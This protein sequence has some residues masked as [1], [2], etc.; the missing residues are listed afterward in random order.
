MVTMHVFE[1]CVNFLLL[2]SRSSRVG[3]VTGYKLDGGGIRFLVSVRSRMFTSPYRPD[4]L[5]SPSKV[6]SN[7]YGGRALSPRVKQQECAA[8]LLPPTSA[9]V[10]NTQTYTSTPPYALIS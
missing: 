4:R 5:W 3:I 2:V 9:E 1:I 7:G 10:K 8:D 6:L